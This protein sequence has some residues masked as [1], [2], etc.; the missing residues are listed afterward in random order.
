MNFNQISVYFVN[1][2]NGILSYATSVVQPQCLSI[3]SIRI[4]RRFFSVRCSGVGCELG[5]GSN[6]LEGEGFFLF[7]FL[8]LFFNKS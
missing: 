4:Y 8:Q 7:Y 3:L 5:E 2:W 6:P 1:S